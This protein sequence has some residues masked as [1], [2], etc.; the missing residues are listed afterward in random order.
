MAACRPAKDDP[1][2]KRVEALFE[3]LIG[4]DEP[5]AAVLV[6]KGGRAV[7]AR[8]WGVTDLRTK[9]P[10]GPETN[11]RLA[12]VT[13][14][15]TAMAVM[16]LVRDGKLRYED[17]LT[18]IFPGFPEYGRE[19]TVRRLLN[20]TS[21]LPD[22]EDVMPAPDP[23]LPV[24]SVQISD[25]EVLDL[26]KE[27]TEGKFPPGARWAYSNSGYVLLGLVVEKVS[28][29]TFP[30]FLR[31]RI[32]APLGMTG[33]VVYERGKNEIA[34]RAFGHA[35]ENGAWIEK[36]QSP[37]SAT[38]GDGRVYSSLVDLAKWDNALHRHTL[39]S[40][41]EMAPALAP[42][43]V[44]SEPPTEPDGSPA[45][46]G[47]G[48]FLNPWNGRARMWHYG[49]TSGF[50]TAVHRLTDDGLT[51]VVLCNR[52]DRDASAL[53]LKTAGIYLGGKQP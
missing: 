33:T 25:A 14:P 3:N 11:F 35:R 47:F 40:A 36:D 38:R 49:E 12:S 43:Q 42:V 24:E 29:R 20:H 5:G 22:Y 26:L 17:G 31:E 44:E 2:A 16:L 8:G 13:K 6:A 7:F 37:T 9:R 28:G 53:A 45:A 48:W 4:A 39:M 15:F 21:G 50:R 19:I 52:D 27:R 30:D 18:D 41:E 34:N 46:Y 10:I 23:A 51:V 1:P 32:F